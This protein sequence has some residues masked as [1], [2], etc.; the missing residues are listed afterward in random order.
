MSKSRPSFLLV[1]G[2]NIIH[3]WPELLQRHRLRPG[4][5]HSELIQHL[6]DYRD[7]S[8]DRVVVVFDGRGN[9]VDEERH[10]AGLQVFYT[11]GSQTA[12]DVIERLAIKYA[13][14]YNITVATDDRAEQDIVV[15]AGGEALSSFGLKDRIDASRRNRD[16]WLDRHRRR[17]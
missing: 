5:A 3:A 13:D 10:S 17:N 1:D 14:L 4:S 7:W 9:T 8:E 6:S 15:G 2:N 16:G 12:D 11:S